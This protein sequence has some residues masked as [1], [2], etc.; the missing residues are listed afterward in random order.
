[1]SEHNK[2]ARNERWHL[3]DLQ[4]MSMIVRMGSLWEVALRFQPLVGLQEGDGQGGQRPSHSVFEWVLFEVAVAWFGSR[5]P[6]EAFFAEPPVWDRLR[7][8]VEA[9]YPDDPGRR[10]SRTPITRTDH[11]K[12]EKRYLTDHDIERIHHAIAEAFSESLQQTKT[13]MAPP[14]QRQPAEA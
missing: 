10:L 6:A 4:S 1:M 5:R 3:S 13:M 7:S 2:G 14:I 11:F 12:F 9:A 8:V